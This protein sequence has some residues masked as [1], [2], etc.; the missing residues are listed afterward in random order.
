M[1]RYHVKR[2]QAIQLYSYKPRTPFY[3]IV[4]SNSGSSYPFFP[5]RVLF[6]LP[7]Q[8][9]ECI[10]HITSMCGRLLTPMY[11]AQRRLLANAC[12]GIVEITSSELTQLHFR[13]TF[14]NYLIFL[15]HVFLQLLDFSLERVDTTGCRPAFTF[16][17]SGSSQIR[18]THIS[19]VKL[20]IT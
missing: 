12:A 20:V 5:V 10:E 11:A 4:T 1:H 19:R 14:I 3:T 6:K 2:I 16:I 18:H 9:K 7:S 17:L 15:E 8:E 13:L